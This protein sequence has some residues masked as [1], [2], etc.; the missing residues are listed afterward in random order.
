MAY[1]F[2][3][4]GDYISI[5]K[6]AAAT[7][8]SVFSYSFN[9]IVDSTAGTNHN[10]FWMG[11]TW[12]TNLHS[13]LQ[14]SSGSGRLEFVTGW[15]T[16]H[17]RWSIANSGTSWHNHV[18]TYDFSATT[19]DPV[20]YQDGVSQSITENVAPAGTANYAKDTSAFKIGAGHDGTY[21][22]WD[23]KIAEFA[24]WNRV[25]TAA[26]AAIMGDG[27]SPLFIPNGL[28]FYAPMIRSLP[29][30]KGGGVGTAT[31]AVVYPH[32]RIIYPSSSQM[33]KLKGSAGVSTSVKDL[34]GGFIPF[35]R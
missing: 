11:S 5:S 29:D 12:E 34:I 17:A 4:S 32:P 13:F 31:N 30:L 7:D 21:E 20:W 26:E 35:S 16:N 33:R 8:L 6:S 3:G 27:F 1:D 24:I 15:S 14:T 19:N 23:G 10:V 28:V 25:L 22:F 2:D 18:I 9:L